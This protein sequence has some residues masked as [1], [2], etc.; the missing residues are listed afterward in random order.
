MYNQIERELKCLLTKE[1]HKKIMNS[2]EFPIEIHQSNTYY[3]TQDGYLKK[4]KSAMRI[5]TIN[6]TYIFTLKIRT[7][8]ITLIELEKEVKDNVIEHAFEDEEIQGWL[9]QYKVP[10][11]VEKIVD[12]STVRKLQV[13]ENAE[14]CLD[15]TNFY[16]TIDYELEYE[17]TKDH[18]GIQEFNHILAPFGLSY[19]KNCP[20]KVARAVQYKI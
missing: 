6:D 1:Q 11:E 16:G 9:Q 4:M 13:L 3:D 20:S 10:T 7:D 17:Y 14:L 5:R 2:Y 19:E 8:D 12:F 18:D 15:E